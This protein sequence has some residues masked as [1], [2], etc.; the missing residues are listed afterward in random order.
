MNIQVTGRN[1]AVSD[2][3]R[4]YIDKEAAKLEKFFDRIIDLQAFVTSE[5]R[6]RNV[7]I[8][9]NVQGHTL[10][11]TCEARSVYQAVEGAMD[12]VKV[13]LKK[14]HDKIRKPRHVTSE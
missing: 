14:V 10:K 5:K 2:N 8:I 7:E 11:A 3:L 4:L 13:Q 1:F 9:V 6:V 12:R